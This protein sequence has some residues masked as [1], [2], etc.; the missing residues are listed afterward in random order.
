[1][2]SGHFPGQE[3]RA[4]A[5]LRAA[6]RRGRLANAYLISGPGGPL[7]TELALALAQASLCSRPEA[8]DPCGGCESCRAVAAGR[9][10]DV[11][12]VRPEKGR[13]SYPVRQ[14][15]EEIR[16][17]V[18][19]KPAVGPRRFLII[20]QA[21]GLVRG[22]GGQNEGADALL[23]VL[24]EPPPE[25][26]LVLL[27]AQP[28]RL[29][30][31]VRSRCQVVRLD[32][33]DP[34]ALAGLLASEHRLASD[35]ALF[36]AHLAGCEPEVARGFLAR[37]AKKERPDLPRLRGALHD[38]LRSV[39]S[40]GIPVLFDLAATLDQAA[41]GWPALTGA[42]GVLALLLR[43]ACLRCVGAEGEALVFPGGL[44][45]E[46]TAEAARTVSDPE[47]LGAMTVRALR[48]QED[49]RRYP[50]RL[51][52]LEVLLLDL[53]ELAAGPILPGPAAD[54]AGVETLEGSL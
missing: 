22:T 17:Q 24:E 40:A 47:R 52:L 12:L 20:E 21:D 29:P 48:A 9:H 27:T 41:P 34:G 44:E 2:T 15:R 1:M 25:T 46:V 28:E 38:V 35:E 26:V 43:D 39:G 16:R 23:K 32:P 10:P 13:T 33:S 31:T 49:S 54:A 14:V 50:A 42:L 11:V 4:A 36:V 7:K 45:G 6:L 8:G 37:G 53:Q 19:L 3:P 18:Y 51:L 30:A 5:F